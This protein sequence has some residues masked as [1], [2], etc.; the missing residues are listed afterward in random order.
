MDSAYMKNLASCNCAKNCKCPN[1]YK[2]C[3]ESDNPAGA[4]PTLG[5]CCRDDAKC[6]TSTGHCKSNHVY[7]PKTTRENF[8]VVTKE[9][10][11]D[12]NCD[13]WRGAFWYLVVI[14]VLMLFCIIALSKSK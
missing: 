9:G 12:D 14:I 10:Y 8:V 7:V 6:N 11:N 3:A 5:V 2:C 1:G 4:K 13:N